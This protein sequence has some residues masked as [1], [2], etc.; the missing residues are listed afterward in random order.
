MKIRTIL[1]LLLMLLIAVAQGEGL[2]QKLDRE[3][4]YAA[5]KSEKVEVINNQLLVLNTSSA[6]Q[7]EAFEGTLLMRKAGLVKIPA[8]KLKLFK[9]GRIKLETEIAQDTSNAEYRFLRL[10]IQEHAPKIVKYNKQLDGDKLQIKKQ[11]K[12]LPLVVQ[13][14]IVDYSKS[15]KILR[16]QD[17]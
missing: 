3:A 4:F 11:F 6:H 8:Q 5:I 16:Q 1:L 7:K 17:L 14:A 2:L 15:S 10:I 13:D 12:S 9:E